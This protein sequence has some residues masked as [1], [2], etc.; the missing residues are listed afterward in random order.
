MAFKPC[1]RSRL[2]FSGSAK[3]ASEWALNSGE[4]GQSPGWWI[5]YQCDDLGARAQERLG[6]LCV[7]SWRSRVELRVGA[8]YLSANRRLAWG[9]RSEISRNR[10]TGFCPARA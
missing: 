8:E 3:S 9:T 7:G 1:E 5:Q 2:G 6:L 10:R 4:Y